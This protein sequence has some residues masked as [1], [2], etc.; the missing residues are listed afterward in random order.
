MMWKMSNKKRKMAFLTALIGSLMAGSSVGAANLMATIPSDYA[1]S[2]MGGVTGSR[3]TTKVDAAPVVGA[4]KNLNRDPATFSVMIDG[5][6]K[7][8]LRQY[9]YGNTELKGSILM[10]ADGDW[11]SGANPT[12]VIKAVPNAHAVTG[13][14]NTIYATGYDQGQVGIAHVEDDQIAEDTTKTVDL[15]QD[16]K[17]KT[18]D[19]DAKAYD[20]YTDTNGNIQTTTVHGEGL[21]VKDGYLYVAASVNLK[22]G[23]DNYDNGYLMQYK[24]NSDGGLS[25]NGYARIGKNAEQVKLNNYNHLILNTSAGGY[26]N[27]G[28]VNEETS[29]DYVNINGNNI[30]NLHDKKS[31]ILPEQVKNDGYD[32]RDMK[33]LPD[34]TVYVMKYTLSATGG[35]F[36]G[37]VYQTTMANLMSKNP[38]DWQVVLD[39]KVD[40]GWFGRL[41]AEYYTKRLW[42]EWGNNLYVYEDGDTKPTHQWVTKDFSTDTQFGQFNSVTMLP[43]DQVWGSLAKLTTYRPEG[44]TASSETK[45]TLENA[46]AK[47]GT[48]TRKAGITGTSA[49]QTAFGDVTSDDGTYSFTKDEVL[50]INLGKEGDHATNAAA[51]IQAKDGKDITI[52]ASGHTLQLASKNYIASPVGIYAGNGKNVTITADKVDVVTSGYSSGNSLTNAIWNDGG[53]NTASQITVNGDVNIS[54]SGGYGGN[55]VAIQ[56]SFRWGENS[57]ESTVSS[58][59]TIHGNLKIAGEDSATWGIPVNQENVLSRFNNAGIL[60]NIEKSKVTV[61][62][63]V[64]MSVY[65]NGITTNAVGSEVSIGGGH[66]TVPQ[67]TKYGYYTLGAY[68]G[69]INVNMNEVGSAAGTHDVQLDGDVFALKSTGTINLGLATKNSYLHGIVDNGG[70]VNMWLQ[71][72]AVWT[73]EAKNTRYKQDDEDVG[74]NEVSRVTFLHGGTKSGTSDTAGVIIQTENSKSLTIDKFSGAAKVLYSHDSNTPTKI[75]GGDVTIG[76]AIRGSEIVLRTDYD[77]NM[78]SDAVK[79]QVLNALAKKLYYKDA[80]NEKT[81]LS[82]KVEIAEGLTASSAAKY[83]GNIAFN[84][85]NGQGSLG[86]GET[87]EPPAEQSKTLFTS[88]MTGGDDKEYKDDHVWQD[89]VY[90]FTKDKTTVQVEGGA[91][92]DAAKD[93][94]ITADGNELDLTG[95]EAGIRAAAGKTVD[96]TAGILKVNGKTGIDAAGTVTLKGKSEITGTE[97]AVNVQK[98]GSVTL[99]TS[100]ISGDVTNGGHLTLDAATTV[101]GDITNAGVLAVNGETH[102]KDLTTTG[103]MTV[104]TDGVLAAEN[105]NVNGGTFTANGSVSSTVKADKG[106]KAILKGKKTALKGLVSG[107]QSS[108]EATLSGKDS[109]LNGSLEGAGSVTLSLADHANWTGN[110]DGNGAY[111]VSIGK[112]STWTGSSAGNNTSLTLDGIWNNQGTSSLKQMTGNHG[113]ID[114]TD[115]KAGTVTI[116]NYGGSNTYIYKHDTTKPADAN[117]GY[118]ILGGDVKISHADKGSEITLLTDGAGLDFTS[119]KADAK[120]LISGTLNALA[121]KLYYTGY[122]DGNLSGTVK[123]AEGLTASSASLR[124]ETITFST[125]DTSTKKAG[126]GFYAYTPEEDAKTYETGAIKKSENIGETRESDVNGVVSVNVT[127]AQ[128]GVANSAPSA[129]YASSDLVDSL[130]VDLQGHALQLS[131]GGDANKYLSTVYVAGG[132]TI[133][134]KDS[135]GSGSVKISAGVGNDGNADNKT[136]YTYG[137]QVSSEGSLISDAN[138][139]VDGVKSNGNSRA[140]GIYVNSSGQVAFNK[141]LTIKGVQN[142]NKVGANTAGIYLSDNANMTIHGNMDIE[143]VAGYAIRVMSGATLTTSGG[144]IKA[145]DMANGTTNSNY[146]ALFANKGTINLNTGDGIT[147]GVLDMTGDMKVT[148]NVASAINVNLT[149]GSQWTGAASNTASSSYNAPSGQINMSMTEGSCWTHQT[150]MSADT[151]KSTFAGSNISK[152]NSNGGLVYQNSDKAITVYNY[153][154]DATVVYQHDANDPLTIKGG[155]FTIKTATAGSKITL[156]T[157]SQGINGGF[158]DGDTAAEKNN[159]KEVLNKLANKLFYTGYKDANLA[160]VVKIADGLTAS[161]VSAT[162]KASGDVTFSD[163]TNG[164][165]KAG[166]GFYAYTPEQEKPNYK[167]GAITKS[168]DISLS[169]ELDKSGVAHVTVAESNAGSDKFASALYAGESTDASSPMTVK[170]SGKGLALHVDQSSGQA[171]AIY[172][173][174]NAYIHVI[175]PSAD[176]KLT[177]T[178]NNTDTRGA[179]G[180]YADAYAHLNISGPVEITDITTKGDS[181]TGINIQGKQSEI[182]IDGSLTIGNVK[183]I[184]ERGAGMNASGIQVTGDSSTVTVSGPVDISGVRGSGIKLAGKDTKVSVGGGTITAAEDSDHSNNFYAVRV[185]KGTLDINMKDGAAGSTTTK[186]TGDMYATGQYGKKVVEYTGGE[187]IDWKDA[188]ILNVA[189]TDKDSFWKGVAAYD[190]YTDDYGTGGSTTHDIGQFNLYLQN[191]ATWTNEQ[192]SHV[193]TT[194]IASKN[195]V[196]EGSTLATLNGGKDADNAG[197]IYQKDTNPISVVNYSGHTTV[198]YEHDA[199]DPA[200]IIGGSFNITNAADGSAITFI[201]DNKGITS[202]FADGDSSVAKDKV[203]NVLNSLA[204]KLFYKNYTDGHLT[205]VV[206][207]A[208]GLT[209]S[210]AALKTGDISFS[211]DQTGTGVAGQGYYAYTTSKP[212]SQTDKEF[213]AAITGDASVDTVYVDKGVLKDDGTYV[214]TADSTTI[215]PE[216]HL[217]AGGAY[218]PQI[219]A[220]IS[221]SDE[222]HNV[223]MD[224]NGNKL[225]V[226]TTTDT[227]T[228][229][230]AAIGKGVVNINNAGAMSVSATS[231]KGGQTGALFV[232]A[233]GTINIHNAGADNVLTLRAK[234]TV[235]VNAAVIKSMNGVNGVMSSITVDGLV[236]IL[237]EKSNA[238]GANEAISAV[239]SKVEVGGGVIKAINGAEYAIRAYGEYVSKNRGQVNVNVEKDAEGAIIGAGSNH[240]QLEGNIYLGGG[241]DNAGASADVSLGLNTKDSFWKGDVSNTKGSSAGIVNLYM[242]SGAS[243]T[244]NN[245]SGNT[246]NAD[247]DNATWTG[248]SNGNAMHLKL[249]NSIW[250]V[251]GASKIASFSGNKGSIF[252]ASD[253]GDISVG[254]YSGNTTVIYNHDADHPTDILG[255]SFT[256]GQADADS[257]ITL[258]TD[259]QGITKGFNAYDKAE[260][261]NTVNEVLNKLAQKLFYTAN[262]GKLAGTVK[263]ASGLTASSAALKTGNIS[264]STDATGTKTLGQGFYE[265]TVKDDSVITDRIT[266][267]LDKKYVNL[268]IETEKGIYNFTQDAVIDVTKG[269]Y[270]SGLGVI[271]SSGGPI[272]INAKGQALEAAYHVRKGSN[273]ARAVATGN[274]YGKSKDVTITAKSLKLNTDTTGFRAQGVYATG[275]QITI[276]ADTTISTSAQTESNGIYSGNGGTVTMSGNLT[277]QKDSKAANYMALKSDDNGVI[278]VNVKDGKAGAGIVKID[279][280]VFTKSAESYDDWEDETTST[281]S[282]VNLAL[283]GKDSIWNGRSLYEVSS[284]EDSTSYGTF[285][286][287]LTDGATWTNEKNG[288]EVPS[289][290]A[291]SHVTKLTGGSDAAHAGNIFQN[292]TKKIT[293]DNYSGNTNIYYA[294]TGNGEAASDYAAGDTII[295]H[296]E[297]DSVVSLITDNSGVNMSSADSIVNVLNSLAGKLTYS[298]FTKDENNLTGYVKIADGLTSSSAAMYTGDMAFSKKDGKGSLKDEDSIRPDLPAPDH[299]IKNEFTTTLTGVKSKD[300]EYYKAGVIKSDGLYQFTQNSSITTTNA[301]GA[302][303]NQATTID[304]KG[305]TLTFNT[306]LTYGTTV[307]AIGANS[308]DGVTINASKLVLNAHSTNGR[309]EGI[310][311]GQGALTING[312]TEMNIKG[313]GYTLGL[314]AA[315]D[316]A[317]TFNG[318]VTAM[319]DETSE[320][321]LTAKNGAWGYY[322]CSLV[323]SDSN[324]GLQKGP[325]VTINGDVNAKIDGNCLF[326][327][328]GHAKLTINGGGN[329]EINKDNEHTY[330][331]MIAECGT[332][333]M[334]VNLDENYDAVSA[335]DN[336]LVLKGNIG[337][338]TGAISAHETELY[339]KVNLGLAT[340]DSVWTGVAHNRFNDDG[341]SAYSSDKKFYGAINVFLQNG[342]T[343]NNEKWGATYKPWGSSG[344]AGSHVAKF[345]GGSDV[346]HAGNIFQNDQN[347]LTIDNY[348]GNTNIYYAHTGNG[349]AASDYVAG[350]TIIRSAAEGSAVSLITDN[351]GI[352]MDNEYSV[353]NVLNALAGKLT[354]SSFVTG[355]KNLTG[356][357]KIADG[358]TA[359][360]A[361]KQTG[362]IA[363]NAD[364]GKGSLE[365][366][367]MKPG[368]TYPETQ[369]PEA[370]EK[371]QGITGDAK[372]DYQY[373]KD[374]I[375]KEDGSYVFTQNPTKIEVESGAAVDATDK[376]INIDTTKAKLELKG[377]TGIHAN[378]ADVTVNG[379]TG[380]SGKVGIDA[381]NGNVTLN[382]STD[383]VG[384][385]AAI[386]AGEGGNVDINTNNSALNIKGDINANG[387]SIIVDSSKATGVIDGDVSASNGGSVEISLNDAKS[388]LTGSYRVDDSSS[389]VMN[390]A[391]GATWNLT[392]DEDDA[393]GMSLFRMAKAPAATADKGLTINGGE[394]KAKTGYLNMTKRTKNL[395]IASYSGWET[396]IYGHENAGDKD[397][398]YKSGNTIINKAAKDSGVILS[399]DNSGINMGDKVAVEATLKALAHK[400]TY[401]DHEENGSNLTGKVQIADGLTASSASKYLGNMRWDENGKGQ[402]VDGSIQWEPTIEEGEY[403][404]FVMKGARSAVTTSFHSWRDNMQDTYTGADL[405]DEDGIFAKALGGK[406]SSDVSGLKDSNSYWGAQIGYDKALANGWHTGVAFDYRDGDSDYLLGGKGD[407]KLYS[408]GVYGVKKMDNGSYFRVAAKAGRVENEYDVYTELRNKLH[409]DYKANAY[410]LTAEYGK[411]FGSEMSYITPKVLLTWSRVGSK[412]YAG[413]ANN[414]AIMNI[415][416]DSYDSLVGRL[417]FEAGMKKANGSLHA[418]LYLAHEFNGDIDTRYFAKDGGWKSTSFDGDDT[419][420]EL[421]LGGEYRLGRN[422]QLYADFARDLGGDFQ[423]KWKLNAGIRLRF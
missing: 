174:N 149:K 243:W 139:E 224:M 214:L 125:A 351:S 49:D 375:L 22:G 388:S 411:T 360:S 71:N 376:D 303:M 132:K 227:H 301:H 254:D 93:V 229:G 323:Y 313:V 209:A 145:M 11:A 350:D 75:L 250:N 195:P 370:T 188:G 326:A 59:I 43:T 100:T 76:S 98:G 309:I 226:D 324:Y 413:S 108:I 53:K 234:S 157:D 263:I 337:A 343:W 40:D 19:I 119:T 146:Y 181:A 273:V 184:R 177:I 422:S 408:F 369:K 329:I 97:K 45:I 176:Q 327:K 264:F 80:V 197:L 122:A 4:V 407:N 271:E 186:I 110:A 200:K 215:T 235:P 114:M 143:N 248:Y 311:V 163:G 306:D 242:G 291:G 371:N 42:V 31:I 150:G 210:S 95:G 56:K 123:I 60:T 74:S 374:G 245:L 317:L 57:Q 138:V 182:I 154:G 141:D 193:T 47:I 117:S 204:G 92:V 420:A 346:A 54:M 405:A 401:T 372:T 30:G 400:L 46:D 336:K 412:D 126:Q 278:N 392:D 148:D 321:G 270:S 266:G 207:I 14:G 1:N 220:A 58:A 286:L 340:A 295:K 345:V 85:T 237:A 377:E 267:D 34:G 238:S 287:W 341:N 68:A 155:D 201:T 334:N 159:V 416:Q 50:S 244:G 393:E 297:K 298:N 37:R 162:V 399:T 233:G 156:V 359:S 192:Q 87:P 389:I 158:A 216:K 363:F 378:G 208:D 48:V 133:Q 67:G 333:S 91:A 368:F 172:A 72:G 112:D 96:I 89:Q 415:Y 20:T 404:T 387:G 247:L 55:G 213:T 2:Q 299:Q 129:L 218:V 86:S 361:A 99:G 15:K 292:D 44:F 328:G 367:S 161:S 111:A 199:S 342:A 25:Y 236:D 261:Q 103:T 33:V 241:M 320:W 285:N 296:A 302:D 283:Q 318:N 403:E 355:E 179:H 223:T 137:I 39:G 109:A 222:K 268:G 419:W 144:V 8:F 366:G 290:F 180:I 253:A 395:N 421:V 116:Q 373:K 147:A 252:V 88:S 16:I 5:E 257:H 417:G 101:N 246:V 379:N 277:I 217:I 357:V 394:S 396:I 398:D 77:D 353:A 322:R 275:G 115:A 319:G 332:T 259:N 265:Y 352:A 52:D 113:V 338:S 316:S 189:L 140:Y 94:T 335:R 24:I 168:E 219:G 128:T 385:D 312:N 106:G 284:G 36:T 23:Y 6:S 282:T 131:T 260:D 397:E 307:H 64:D 151:L 310:N 402:Y 384:T 280:D 73:N 127:D 418:G 386:N 293:I 289:G 221:G 383:I 135:S 304:A 167:T 228:T 255:G 173:G 194:T 102:A 190:Q 171:A 166:Q 381:A 84:Q 118:A 170:M 406:T 211:T 90:T 356:Y 414:G 70:K 339:T 9:V 105:I 32:F 164:T 391:N 409:A 26:Q 364:T 272:T 330:Y 79:N 198:F 187:L 410:G 251:N 78:Q 305:K 365:N 191:G 230:I 38:D 3:V 152:L 134:I 380:I 183:G 308:T 10:D 7:I 51:V 69:T 120:N 358:L 18:G 382:G 325:K 104:G 279:G 390:I 65:G 256:I 17:E 258:I 130:V 240:V 300:K 269:D 61:T 314:Y 196:W 231:T 12:G 62:G 81:A 121:G 21:L 142:E 136:N 83:I 362:N 249:D 212:G 185:D 239:A 13:F 354:Y 169:R 281:S 175:N 347:T 344:F 29:L 63:D 276:D 206:K 66:I 423:R 349:E 331:A 232:N 202:G 41:N 294:H 165:K 178:A 288:K 124:S 27:Y 205:G 82:G 274:S 153:N 160:G 35:E 28:S 315:G 348:S 107:D 203:A 262:D 225:T